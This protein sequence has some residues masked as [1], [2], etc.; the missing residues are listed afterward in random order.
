MVTILMLPLLAAC[1]DGSSKAPPSDLQR[2]LHGTPPER[3]TSNPSALHATHAGFD[4]AADDGYRYHV[5]LP[6]SGQYNST[7]FVL[8]IVDDA[9]G[10]LA[11][12]T[13]AGALADVLFIL[14]EAKTWPIIGNLVTAQLWNGSGMRHPFDNGCCV[15]TG[16]AD[17]QFVAGL[18][19]DATSALP[20]NDR[21]VIGLSNGGMLALDLLYNTRLDVTEYFVLVSSDQTN[22]WTVREPKAS[23]TLVGVH[24]DEV[25]PFFGG[26]ID[27]TEYIGHI[28][29]D[30]PYVEAPPYATTLARLIDG[31]AC[32]SEPASVVVSPW[33][34]GIITERAC[35]HGSLNS[36]ELAQG[37]HRLGSEDFTAET[38]QRRDVIGY[39]LRRMGR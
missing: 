2:L 7:V 38:P 24:D 22:T 36:F 25:I 18:I 4:C 19:E 39:M 16:L 6:R 9:Q 13:D 21:Y 34:Q 31:L 1:L 17:R 3:C 33:A 32:E 23:V 28:N 30:N 10:L 37:G 15:D 27:A 11:A 14:P 35:H 26:P 29:A 8:H 12:N 20:G 5:D